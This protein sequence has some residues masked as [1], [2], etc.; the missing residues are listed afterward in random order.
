M[1]MEG[2][3]WEREKFWDSK[4]RMMGWCVRVAM[5]T[6]VRWDDHGKVM[7]QKEAY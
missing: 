3:I 6:L 1:S 7:N 5:M 2:R 4:E